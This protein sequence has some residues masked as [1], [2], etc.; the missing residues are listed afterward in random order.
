MKLSMVQRTYLAYLRAVW[1][2]HQAPLQHSPT[3]LNVGVLFVKV[4]DTL[5]HLRQRNETWVASIYMLFQCEQDIERQYVPQ[6][7][8]KQLW[9]RSQAC[10]GKQ[11]ACLIQTC[12][13]LPGPS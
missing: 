5:F 4:L 10:I 7:S 8:T 9:Q 1:I 2:S 11:A 13:A 6:S 3:A 12:R